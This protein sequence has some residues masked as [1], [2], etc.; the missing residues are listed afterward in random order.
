MK[1]L[2]LVIAVLAFFVLGCGLFNRLANSSTNVATNDGTT[3]SSKPTGGETTSPSGDPRAD[4]V[5]ASKKFIDLPQFSAKMDGKSSKEDLHMKLDYAAP[6]RFHM[7]RTDESGE[8]KNEMI[9]I[10]KDMY[11]QFGGSWQKMP[12]AGQSMPNLRQYFDEKGLESLKDVKY[13]GSDTLDGRSMN[14]YSYQNSQVNSNSPS[15]FTSKIWV[16]AD[17]GLPHK[18]EVT[19]E[20]GELKS[21]TIVYDFNT[22]INIEPPVTK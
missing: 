6:D 5:A 13:E 11:M 10:G 16:G 8:T 3:T 7:M 4:V 20:Q 19:Y 9:M 1:N 15:P 17:D 22:P 12:N 18:I 14:L 2:A 21:M